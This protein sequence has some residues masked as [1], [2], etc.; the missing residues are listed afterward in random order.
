MSQLMNDQ[1]HKMNRDHCYAKNI[2]K[3]HITYIIFQQIFIILYNLKIYIF[4]ILLCYSGVSDIAAV[5]LLRMWI[6]FVSIPSIVL[7]VS[8][9]H[10][11]GLPHLPDLKITMFLV[12]KELGEE[13]TSKSKIGINIMLVH[14]SLPSLMSMILIVL[15]KIKRR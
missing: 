13:D 14:G 2:V 3:Y 6:L 10:F 4:F 12:G 15:K 8:Y 7:E 9:R 1:V 5:I 11:N